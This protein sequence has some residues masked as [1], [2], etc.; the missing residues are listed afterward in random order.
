MTK[1]N[2]KLNKLSDNP[3]ALRTNEILGYT[4]QELRDLQ[5]GDTFCMFS[6]SYD[7]DTGK[8]RT[9][10]TSKIKRVTVLTEKPALN[11]LI[12]VTQ[13][14]TYQIEELPKEEI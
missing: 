3:N 9:I 7:G 8:V 2:V 12:L 13:N 11:T 4:F 10:T 14:S 1:T 6:D 5:A